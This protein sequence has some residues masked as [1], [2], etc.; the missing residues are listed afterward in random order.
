MAQ[1]ATA[2]KENRTKTTLVVDAGDTIQ[3]NSAELFLNDDVHPM[4]AAQ[5]AI[6]YDVYVTGNMSTTMAWPR[7]KRYSPSRRPRC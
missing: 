3:A 6:G 2:I 4:I 7:W 5:N 1:Q